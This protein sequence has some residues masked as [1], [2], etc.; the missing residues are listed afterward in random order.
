M[1]LLRAS[2]SARRDAAGGWA[3]LLLL[4]VL[5]AAGGIAAEPRPPAPEYQVKAAFL[6]NFAQFVEWP[7]EALD[8]ADSPIVIGV[9][10]ENPFGDYLDELVRNEQ[11]N[12]HP[13]HVRRFARVEE[14]GPCHILFVSRSEAAKLER[15]IAALRGRPLLTVGEMENFCRLGGIVRFTTESGRI[16]LRI[17]V[18]TARASRLVI[19]SKLLRWATI[20]PPDKD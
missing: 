16:R 1:A 6:F 14:V 10:G 20:V 8:G 19:S 12:G 13:L 17:S 2:L 3:A 18:E 5:L 15:I 7:R 4:G 9:L 11:I